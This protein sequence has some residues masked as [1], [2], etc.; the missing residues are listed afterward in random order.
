MKDKRVVIVG[1]GL[2][3]SLLSVMLGLRGYDVTVFEKRP[4]MRTQDV[5][6]GRSIN[7]ALAQRGIKALSA[8]GLME[9][10]TPLLIPMRGRQLHLLGG[11]QEFSP[12]G[13]REHEVIYSVSRELLNSLMMT[14]AEEHE[15]VNVMFEHDC[16]TIDFDKKQILFRDL[17]SDSDRRVEYDILIGCD[18]AGSRVRRQMMPLV[19][20]NSRSEFL[21]HDYKEL[22]IPPGPSGSH[23]IKTEA[24]HI[25]PRGGYM[26]IALPNLDGSFTVTLFMPKSGDVSFETLNDVDSVNAFFTEQFPSALELIP[27]LASEFFENPTGLLGTLR[28]EPWHCGDSAVILGDAAH[29]VVPFHGQG[30]NAA[31]EDCDVL[32]QLLD[33]FEHDW[34]RT[35]AEFSRIRKPNADAIADMALENY[36]T[37]R[38]SVMDEQFQLKKEVGF[39]LERR[40]PDRFI[41]R[42]SMVMFHSI[43]YAEAFDRG[44]LQDELLNEVT[45]GKDSI[46]EV[47]FDW[48][49]KLVEERLV[50]AK[51][52]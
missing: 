28:C 2:A 33:D 17:A 30:M 19:D 21:D 46:D 10:V 6:G 52:D 39:E 32:C 31:F 47:D 1:G 9:D 50:P 43:G 18:G 26:L 11:Q 14:A 48:A 36:V 15:R 51:L 16:E 20:G 45:A 22:T 40:H 41:P 7:L 8:A 5:D 12:Y 37:M 23:Q 34:S 13:Q 44:N 49:T 25:W 42:Y 3:G 29:A 35:I 4:D 24:L 27:D 38:D